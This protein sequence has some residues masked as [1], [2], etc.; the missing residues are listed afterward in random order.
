MA[1]S[2]EEKFVDRNPFRKYIVKLFS[3]PGNSLVAIA[4]VLLGS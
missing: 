4:A 1:F 3:L 2:D